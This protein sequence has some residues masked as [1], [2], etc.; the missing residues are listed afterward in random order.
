MELT[1]FLHT[2]GFR[3][4][5]ADASLFIYNHDNSL[6]FYTVYVDGNVLTGNNTEFVNQFIH[7]L[8]KRFSIKDLGPFHHFLGIELIPTQHAIFLS[9]HRHSQYILTHFN[10]DDAI[11]VSTPLNS[12]M[13]LT[14][15]DD[16]PSVDPK[17][18][19]KL[20]GSL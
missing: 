12:F 17:P 11:E 5:R 20:V 13:A 8:A 6:C 7:S 9:Q 1:S 2:C 15:M 14:T 10:M 18:Y 19:R 4:S 3:K 16:S